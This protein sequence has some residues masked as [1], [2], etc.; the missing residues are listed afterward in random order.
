MIKVEI[1]FKRSWGLSFYQRSGGSAISSRSSINRWWKTFAHVKRSQEILETCLRNLKSVYIIIAELM[2]AVLLVRKRLRHSLRLLTLIA[3]DSIDVR[4]M[5]S[6]QS[7]E[8]TARFFQGIPGLDILGDRL[9]KDIK[10]F[11][12]IESSHRADIYIVKCWD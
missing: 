7:D 6:C 12:K 4:Y 11:W 8:D 1:L 3:G 10:N 2:N 9:N 5:F